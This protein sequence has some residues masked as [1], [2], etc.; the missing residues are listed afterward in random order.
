MPNAKINWRDSETSQHKSHVRSERKRILGINL[1]CHP[2]R[3][4]AIGIINRNVALGMTER[5]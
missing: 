2:E 3:N 1:I 5:I 4:I